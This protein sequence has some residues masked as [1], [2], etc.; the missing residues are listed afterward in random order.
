[1]PKTLGAVAVLVAV[2]V[3]FLS[4][5]FRGDGLG[6]ATASRLPLYCL[7]LLFIGVLTWWEATRRRTG[8]LPAWTSP[9]ALLAGWTL[10]WIYVPALAA[11]LD[12]SLFDNLT[13]AR[14]G[15]DVLLAG[16]PVTCAAL[17]VLS[18][19]YHLTSLAFSRLARAAEGAE[20]HVP[21]RRA[22]GLYVVGTL[23]R[24]VRLQA[25]GV[26]FGADLAA[27]ARCSRWISG[28][29]TSRTSGSSRSRCWWRTS[30]ADA[31]DSSGSRFP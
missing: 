12:D 6:F 22:L 8:V 2:G 27:G 11:F 10:A 5:A 26:G 3:F 19:S 7:G 29:A 13:L 14:G 4:A 9:P 25:L 28:S 24:A 23:A 16:L 21:L 15:E 17:A 31:R 30:C 20:R 1:M 18:L